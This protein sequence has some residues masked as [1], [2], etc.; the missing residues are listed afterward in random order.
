MKSVAILGCGPSGMMAAHAALLSGWD[1]RIYSRKVKSTLHGAQYL[2]QPIPG[3]PCGSPKLVRY[4]LRG[5]PEDY[6]RKVYGDDWDG[7]VSPEDFEENHHAWDLRE[8]YNYLWDAHEY[9]IAPIDISWSAEEGLP[10][11]LSKYDMVISTV[12]RTVWDRD[13]RHFESA[14]IWAKGDR[15]GRIGQ[16]DNTI[17]CNAEPNVAWYR[18]AKI[19]GHATFEWPSLWHRDGNAAPPMEG[20]VVV[21][22]PLRYLGNAM[23]DFLHMGRYGAWEKGVLTSDVFFDAMKAFANDSIE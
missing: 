13:P 16:P 20:A 11:H 10:R 18:S 6:R 9:D 5:T 3:L 14:V 17:E 19:F 22:K 23:P 7:T 8:A 4:T 15:V 2:H 21:R 1:F 12:P